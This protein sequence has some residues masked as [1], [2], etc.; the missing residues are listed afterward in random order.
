VMHDHV[1]RYSDL[2]KICGTWGRCH[3]FKRGDVDLC[4]KFERNLDGSTKLVF[5]LTTGTT[6]DT[7]LKPR[8]PFD[9]D[10]YHRY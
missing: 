4:K 8:L 2:S 10:P 9:N 3:H 6:C 7:F 1:I 5:R